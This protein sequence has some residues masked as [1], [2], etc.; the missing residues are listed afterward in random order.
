MKYLNGRFSA[1]LILM[2]SLFLVQSC[3]VNPVTGK[4]QLAFMS[5]EKEI[6][7]GKSYDPQV[8]TE[9]GKYENWTRGQ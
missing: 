9:M 8:V 6:A 4:R 1:I 3:Q 5:E 7:L 2:M